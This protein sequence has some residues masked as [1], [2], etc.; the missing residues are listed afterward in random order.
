MRS[1][2]MSDEDVRSK[3]DGHDDLRPCLAVVVLRLKHTNGDLGVRLPQ[4]WREAYEL[5]LGT[6]R[7][8]SVVHVLMVTADDC[9]VELILE[10]EERP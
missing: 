9:N 3:R 4:T 8:M 2:V 6:A 1:Y 10:S 7:R 5:A